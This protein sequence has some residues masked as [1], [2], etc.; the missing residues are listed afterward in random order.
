MMVMAVIRMSRNSPAFSEG[1][2]SFPG[3]A[4]MNLKSWMKKRIPAHLYAA[5]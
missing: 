3:R 5:D 4:A 2:P 1:V